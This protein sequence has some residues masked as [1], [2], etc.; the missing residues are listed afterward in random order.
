M[1][2]TGNGGCYIFL[3]NVMKVDL[4]TFVLTLSL[5]SPSLLNAQEGAAPDTAVDEEAAIHNELVA[6]REG[7][8]KAIEER[9]I[10]AVLKFVHK[11]VVVTWQNNDVVR[12]EAGMR[13]FWEA[14][15]AT[16]DVFKYYTSKPAATEKTIL[17]GGD[18]GIVF[19]NSV[20]HYAIP[21]KEFDMENR[22]SAT[23]LKEDGRW[24]IG[25]YHVSANVLDN[26]V[27]DIAKSSLSLVGGIMLIVGIVLGVVGFAIIRRSRKPAA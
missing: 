16:R 24:V 11:N 6:L 18:M 12:G 19:G 21:G 3:E 2:W 9:D 5:F 1:Q 25:S 15:G 13:D 23:V 4:V 20:G 27:L 17:Y 22:W 14:T 26:P 8:T 10:D 7:L